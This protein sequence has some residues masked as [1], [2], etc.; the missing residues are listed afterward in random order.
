[1]TL[2][3]AVANR[4]LQCDFCYWEKKA[5]K[6]YLCAVLRPRNGLFYFK[7]NKY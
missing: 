5:A 6:Y 2:T 4:H 1:M 3:S 7:N